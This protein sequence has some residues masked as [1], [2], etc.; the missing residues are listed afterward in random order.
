MRPTFSPHLINGPFDDP[1]LYIRFLFQN[2]A[3]LFDLGDLS[4]LTPRD[5][6]K[7][8]HVF[9]SH[10]HMDHFIGF[11]PL[12]RLL[13]GRPK[14][15]HLYGPEGFLRNVEGK[16]AG[17]TWNLVEN[18]PQSLLLEVTEVRDTELHSRRY[19]CENK[20]KAESTAIR[21]NC[22]KL[23][24]ESA[25]TVSAIILDHG[26]SCL[27]FCLTERFHV[28]IRKEGLQ[29]LELEPGP[30]LQELKNALFRN[31]D[32]QTPIEVEPGGGG[33]RYSLPLETLQKNLVLITPGQKIGYIA[34]VAPTV[35][36]LEKIRNFVAGADHLFIEAAFLEADRD[37]ALQKRHLTAG[38]AGR[39]AA[40][41][42]V[43]QLTPFHFSPRYTDQ[44]HR[45]EEEARRAFTE[46]KS[47]VDRRTT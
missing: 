12:L 36:N 22:S 44:G 6:L 35:D 2:R 30:W 41:A 45:L 8:S 20:F 40:D 3:L 32:P 43:K 10:T 27:G 31:A 47:A 42:G 38:L 25:I 14:T 28:N 9:V 1:G 11:D 39:L 19:A 33:A 23:V 26:V 15:L 37:R 29:S 18:Y 24:E 16:L 13:M 46:T 17:Y 7:I 21:A 5:L 34:D 4:G